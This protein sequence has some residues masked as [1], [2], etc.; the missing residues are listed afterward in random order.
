MTH[1]PYCGARLLV[2]NKQGTRVIWVCPNYDSIDPH[3][4]E[5]R[6]QEE[7]LVKGA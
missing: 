5:V 1:C 6:V 2:L 3:F 4:G 7:N